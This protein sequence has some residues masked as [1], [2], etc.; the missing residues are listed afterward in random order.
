[1][2]R[3]VLRWAGSFRRRAGPACRR[4]QCCPGLE[5]S[6]GALCPAACG[7]DAGAG[8]AAGRSG[9]HAQRSAA[10]PN[11][12]EVIPEPEPPPPVEMPPPVM[13]EVTLPAPEPPPPVDLRPPRAAQAGREA[14]AQA[15]A[16]QDDRSAGGNPS[17]QRPPAAAMPAPRRIRR[18]A[19]L[20]TWKG[21]LPAPPGETQALSRRRSAPFARKASPMSASP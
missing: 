13:A 8:A 6:R 10:G 21:L 18:A 15:A 16:A 14:P 7:S 12:N 20:P 17:R 11:L 2:N 9:G 4:G 5:P 1:M 3:E 19:T